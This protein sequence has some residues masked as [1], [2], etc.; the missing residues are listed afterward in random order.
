MKRYLLFVLYFFTVSYF[1]AQKN[2]TNP[3]IGVKEKAEFPHAFFDERKI[4]LSNN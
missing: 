3:Y 2:N 1:S 4:D